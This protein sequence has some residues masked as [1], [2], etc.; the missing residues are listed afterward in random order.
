MIRNNILN[1]NSESFLALINITQAYLSLELVKPVNERN[2][3]NAMA[4]YNKALEIKNG[5]KN[6]T[7]TSLSQF[8]SLKQQMKNA[9]LG[10]D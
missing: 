2:F 1:K 10:V 4:Y 8:T 7:M 3:S 9:G 6:L 5:N